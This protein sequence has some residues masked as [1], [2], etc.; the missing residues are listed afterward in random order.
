MYRL[1]YLFA[2]LTGFSP[3]KAQ[4]VKSVVLDSVVVQAVKEGFD[5][6][7]FI[8]MVKADTSF[9]R[10]FRNLRNAPHD[11]V[12]NMTVFG[13][14][15]QPVASR[16][17]TAIQ[18][19][20]QGRRWIEITSETAT[21]K[22]YD[23]KEEPKTYTAELFDEIFFCTDTL[24]VT[25]YSSPI[26]PPQSQD[27]GSHVD[28]LKTLVFQPGVPVDGVPVVGKRLSVF[29]DDMTQYYDYFI[30]SRVFADSVP[31][32][33][34]ECIA[35]PEAGDYPVLRSLRTWFDRRTFQ[36]VYRDYS[37]RYYG[38]LFDFDVHMKVTMD[39]SGENLYP[40]RIEYAGF[41]DLPARRKET[42]E[43]ELE[44]EIR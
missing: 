4:V 31:C 10:G 20:Y 30:T 44:F 9:R 43:F 11:V 38:L 18:H 17:R 14:K 8:D 42:T 24:Q 21:G 28:K 2:L 32:Y 39:Y 27:G 40:K 25:P 12:G 16:N 7:D 29:D 15:Q 37:Y 1:I 22:F 19:V 23:R 41:W 36:I 3:L 34:F 5:V 13:K 26:T 6:S 35:K 33:V